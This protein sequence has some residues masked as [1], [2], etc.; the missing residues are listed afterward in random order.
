MQ[1]NKAHLRKTKKQDSD[2]R[3]GTWKRLGASGA[4]AF[5]GQALATSLQLCSILVIDALCNIKKSIAS[6]C[7]LG[8]FCVAAA[9]DPLPSSAAGSG[10]GRNPKQEPALVAGCNSKKEKG[11]PFKVLLLV[12][13]TGLEPAA[14]CS[15][16]IGKPYFIDISG[17]S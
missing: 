15:Q 9:A 1:W 14:S 4:A 7:S 3:K 16:M 8:I 10:R 12:E 13:V 6:R 17:Y 11:A 2:S 5:G